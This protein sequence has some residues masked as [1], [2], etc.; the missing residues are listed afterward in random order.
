MSR[1][2]IFGFQCVATSKLLGFVASY[3]GPKACMYKLF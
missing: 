1:M 3:S 2:V